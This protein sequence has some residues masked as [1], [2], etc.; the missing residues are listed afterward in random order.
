MPMQP[1]SPG[2]TLAASMLLYAQVFQTSLTGGPTSGA[3]ELSLGTL[4]VPDQG[5]PTVQ[6][7]VAYWSGTTSTDGANDRYIFRI[8]QGGLAG[9]II[10]NQVLQQP[11]VAG[12]SYSTG[13]RAVFSI[14]IGDKQSIPA[15]SA[16]QYTASIERSAVVGTGGTIDTSAGNA[17]VLSVLVLPDPT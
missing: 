10:G 4:T 16:R 13:I 12:G 3:T 17:G 5:F 8:R 11:D 14:P 9:T 2:E 7:A 6:L 15:G 1:F